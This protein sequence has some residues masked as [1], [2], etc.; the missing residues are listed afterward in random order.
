MARVSWF[1]DA[2]DAYDAI[3]P[4]YPEEAF[5]EVSGFAG[6]ERP[7]V[8]EVGPGT[9]Q[10]TR[11]MVRRGWQVTAVELGP[12][13]AERTKANFAGAPNL[14]VI[15]GAFE[16]VELAEA[17]FDVLVSATAWHWVEQ[18][19]GYEKAA[20]ILRPGGVIALMS[21]EQVRHE[22]EPD[23]FIESQRVHLAVEGTSMD[24][25]SVPTRAETWSSFPKRIDA[26]GHFGAVEQRRWDWDQH[27][28]SAQ[29]ELLVRSYSGTAQMAT[30]KREQLIAGLRALI[31]AEFGGRI[32]RP[33]VAVLAMAKRK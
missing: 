23:F 22:R 4:G 24:L 21:V 8:L 13:L 12:D 25:T 18:P 20:R 27:Y 10:A 7:R 6:T 2:A 11:S 16:E 3:R 1:N 31:D 29:Y 5:D 14:D 28:T 33:L 17:S 9:G 30:D 19:A 15:T 32:T 26:S